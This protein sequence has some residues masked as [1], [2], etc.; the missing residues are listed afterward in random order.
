MANAK[1]IKNRDSGFCRDHGGPL[2]TLFE[3]FKICE[4]TTTTGTQ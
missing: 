4:N 2:T 3:D 1:P